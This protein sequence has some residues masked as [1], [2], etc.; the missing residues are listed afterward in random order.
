MDKVSF[1]PGGALEIDRC[2]R[3]GG[4]WLDHGEIQA[5]RAYPR[6]SLPRPMEQPPMVRKGQCHSCHAPLDRA[7]ERCGVCGRSN[8]L[9]CPHC[10]R[11]MRVE[12]A[13]GLRL[14]ACPTCKGAWFDSHELEAIWSQSFDRALARRHLPRRNAAIATADVGT[15]LLFHAVIFAPDMV[16][17]AAAVG[18]EAVSGHAEALSQLPEAMQAT[19]ELAAQAFEAVG[20]AAGGVFEAVVEIISG[21]F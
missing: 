5:L 1:G 8:L 11:P 6:N 15:E 7:A 12:Q 18:G 13:S 2:A 9:D 16:L 3:C 21:I 20:E 14:D 19:P 10:D 17:P 4:I